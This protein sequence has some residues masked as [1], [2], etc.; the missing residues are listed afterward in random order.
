MEEEKP[1]FHDAASSQPTTVVV[2]R[3]LPKIS[4]E[5]LEQ[6]SSHKHGSMFN[7]PITNKVA[8]GYEDYIKI[9]QD[10]KSIK[11]MMQNGAKAIIA[12]TA[13]SDAP[14]SN[15]FRLP[16]SEDLM[17]PQSIVNGAQLEQEIYRM[18]ANS[19]MFNTGDSDY[20]DAAREMFA[21]IGSRVRAWRD[22]T[23]ES[24]NAA[25]E[26][27]DDAPPATKKRRQG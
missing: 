25:A 15:S 17:P 27:E 20:V 21:D 18:F 3:N 12:A 10:L 7:D 5:L 24:S 11:A 6:I 9:R 13:A 23:E 22:E 1:S 19:V 26:T 2:T 4:K 14:S 16:I 8:E